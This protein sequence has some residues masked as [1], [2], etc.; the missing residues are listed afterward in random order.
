MDSI[1]YFIDKYFQNSSIKK[2]LKMKNITFSSKRLVW[3][4]RLK[5]VGIF[6][7][8]YA[9]LLLI[10]WVHPIGY[11]FKVAAFSDWKFYL[12]PFIVV[13][14]LAILFL[15]MIV[16]STPLPLRKDWHYDECD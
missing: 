14:V 16:E 15:G 8:I 7:I 3:K 4:K 1:F 5:Y 9:L 2:N 11:E 12:I 6:T 10:V 13:I